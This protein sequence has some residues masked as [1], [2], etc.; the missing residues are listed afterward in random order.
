MKIF[1]ISLLIFG[2]LLSGCSLASERVGGDTN[3]NNLPEKPQMFDV[4]G[5]T[6]EEM[7]AR[8]LEACEYLPAPSGEPST[9]AALKLRTEI[10]K[11]AALIIGEMEF[12]SP[13]NQN[14]YLR[15]E[16]DTVLVLARAS[17]E[18]EIATECG[19]ADFLTKADESASEP[20]AS[21]APASPIEPEPEVTERSLSS[22]PD[23]LLK[24]CLRYS[25]EFTQASERGR[26]DLF[27][28]KEWFGH[29]KTVLVTGS[30]PEPVYRSKM[31]A[32][33]WDELVIQE[34][35]N[36]VVDTNNLLTRVQAFCLV[37]TGIDI[38][39]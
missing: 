26:P 32:D 25:I 16:I 13:F 7:S 19:F 28:A 33:F 22:G 1:P 18:N 8:A 6:P 29:N 34:G 37:V 11:R 12:S 15:A 38:M 23:A 24:D 9:K 14:D 39:N 20:D 27:V 10:A 4:L 35:P 21:P 3:A 30:I 5:S 17:L 36:G 31:M 2:L